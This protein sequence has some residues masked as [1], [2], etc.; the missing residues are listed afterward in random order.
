MRILLAIAL[1]FSALSVNSFAAEKQS[2]D[3]FS[4]NDRKVLKTLRKKL[5]HSIKC[6]D[7]NNVGLNVRKGEYKVVYSDNPDD[8]KF[9]WAIGSE[10]GRYEK[11]ALKRGYKRVS[12]DQYIRKPSGLRI[13]C[14]VWHKQ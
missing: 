8:V 9:Y 12:F 1:I 10:Y 5:I 11:R 6:R 4:G 13:R 2:T 14:G 7:T 3:W